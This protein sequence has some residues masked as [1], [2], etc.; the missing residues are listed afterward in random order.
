MPSAWKA[1]PPPALPLSCTGVACWALEASVPAGSSSPPGPHARH[2]GWLRLELRPSPERAGRGGRGRD[3]GG[4]RQRP[5]G[6]GRLGRG[7]G[8][9]VAGRCAFGPSVLAVNRELVRKVRGQGRLVVHGGM[10]RD[11]GL[12]RLYPG[13]DQNAPGRK[14]LECLRPPSPQLGSERAEAGRARRPTGPRP[15]SSIHLAPSPA[16]GAVLRSRG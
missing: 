10:E 16:W 13:I 5:G 4:T 7:R 6:P 11:V 1:L 15:G 3:S 14:G 12:L 9:Q 2:G 8:L